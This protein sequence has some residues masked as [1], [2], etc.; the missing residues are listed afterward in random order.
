MVSLLFMAVIKN[1]FISNHV[2]QPAQEALHVPVHLT[3]VYHMW[4]KSSDEVEG[5]PCGISDRWMISPQTALKFILLLISD[6]LQGATLCPLSP[7]DFRG[8]KTSQKKPDEGMMM[9]V[10]G[11][12]EDAK[13]P[14]TRMQV[15]Y[16]FLLSTYCRFVWGL[17]WQSG[18]ISS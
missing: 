8:P 10:C 9:F 12:S 1:D 14:S 7:D 5:K 3:F 16:L 18:Y 17:M 2:M 6:F 11:L 13:Q 4:S 15:C